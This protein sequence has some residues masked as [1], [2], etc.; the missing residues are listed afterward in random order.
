MLR[1]NIKKMKQRIFKRDRI[2]AIS[3]VISAVLA[4]SIF[5]GAAISTIFFGIPYINDLQ[6]QESLENVEMQFDLIIDNIKDIVTGESVDKN[7]LSLFI[8]KGSLSVNKNEFDRTIIMY[9]NNGNSKYNFTVTGL[10]DTDRWFDLI[11]S[12]YLNIKAKGRFY[13]D[14]SDPN[15]YY[16]NELFISLV[17]KVTSPINLRGRICIFLYDGNII[18]ENLFG[19]IWLFDSD[20]LKFKTQSKTASHEL[21]LEKGGIIYLKNKNSQVK[22]IFNLLLKDNSI[23]I[24]VLQT[25]FLKSF[26]LGGEDGFNIRIS[27]ESSSSSL[28]ELNNVYNIR[29]QLHG[30]NAQTWLS[31]ISNKYIDKFLISDEDNNGIDDTLFLS[32]SHN[33]LDLIFL[34]SIVNL[35]KV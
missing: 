7:V 25:N 11:M 3:T 13:N 29:L 19:K 24:H 14:S 22:Q 28:Q 21:I 30:E 17:G 2:D 12:D 9:S 31:Y 33:G 20:S 15:D 34:N 16:E 23:F 32:E 5:V 10:S 18:P 6:S 27:I 26:V 35:N 4:I 8:E 1:Y